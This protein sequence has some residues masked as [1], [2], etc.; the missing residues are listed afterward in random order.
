VSLYPDPNHADCTSG[1]QYGGKTGV[2]LP[3]GKICWDILPALRCV[4]GFEFF[5]TLPEKEFNNGLAEIVK[6]GAID[7]EKMFALSRVI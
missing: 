4:C 1:Q 6:Y 7:D 3:H 2:D 5:R